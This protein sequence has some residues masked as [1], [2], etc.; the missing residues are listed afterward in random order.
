MK[1]CLFFTGD[2]ITERMKYKKILDKNHD[3][4]IDNYD[5][6]AKSETVKLVHFM[7]ATQ[8]KLFIDL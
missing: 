1:R 3:T 5:Y 6:L 2:L 8:I 7:T 4:N